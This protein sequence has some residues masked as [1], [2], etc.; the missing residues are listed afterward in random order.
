MFKIPNLNTED[1]L[2]KFFI[3]LNTRDLEILE[4]LLSRCLYREK[5]L[6]FFIYYLR[7]LNNESFDFL[8]P[9]STGLFKQ[10]YFEKINMLLTQTAFIE[11]FTDVVL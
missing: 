4:D 7:I 10:S 3:N 2:F 1:L 9:H 11:G 6:Y 5:S 8:Q